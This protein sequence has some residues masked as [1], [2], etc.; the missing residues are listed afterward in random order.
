MLTLLLLVVVS[1]AVWWLSDL[2]AELF[3]VAAIVAALTHIF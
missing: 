2:S 3:T 1:V